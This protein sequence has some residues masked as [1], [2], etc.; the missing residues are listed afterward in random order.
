MQPGPI[1]GVIIKP[2]KKIPDERGM[3]MHMLRNDDPDFQQFGE[4][5]F[6]TAYPGVIKAWHIHTQMTLNYAV[7]SGMIKLVCYDNRE[8]SP[9]KGNFMEIFTGENK[10]ERITIP[11]GVTNGFK[12]IGDKTAI[13]ANCATLP[14][15]PTEILR[16]DPFTKDIP[17]DWSLRHG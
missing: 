2:L 14:H 7:I 1:E 12:V 9:T 4:I 8:D 15:D 5:Y 6:S 16:I 10:Y 17:Y 13:V 11:Q 3:V